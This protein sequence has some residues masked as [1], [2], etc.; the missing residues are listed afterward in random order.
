M[1]N[2]HDT[3]R[4]SRR[5]PFCAVALLV[6]AGTVSPAAAQSFSE[7]ATESVSR[8]TAQSVRAPA[9][10]FVSFDRAEAVMTRGYSRDAGGQI[11]V[12][13]VLAAVVVRRTTGWESLHDDVNRFVEELGREGVR[14]VDGHGDSRAAV[15]RTGSV[16]EAA[17]VAREARASGL[18]EASYVAQIDQSDRIGRDKRGRVLLPA[19]GD[20]GVAF[21][22]PEFANQWYLGNTADPEQSNDL[23]PILN[24][25]FTGAGVTVGV[26]SLDRTQFE[27]GYYS[28]VQ[29]QD[30]GVDPEGHPDLAGGINLT[31]SQPPN[32]QL[33]PGQVVTGMAGLI[34]ARTNNGTGI[35]GIAPGAELVGLISGTPELMQAAIDQD[36]NAIDIQVFEMGRSDP[37]MSYFGL[38]TDQFSDPDADF[39]IRAQQNALRNGRG[40][41]GIPQLFGTGA[42]NTEFPDWFRFI[43]GN[44]VSLPSIGFL[45]IDYDSGDF[46]P[47]DSVPTQSGFPLVSPGPRINYQQLV[48][49][50][51]AIVVSP[52]SQNE[53]FIYDTVMGTEVLTSV[54]AEID[55]D[56]PDGMVTLA[57]SP[58][59]G[60]DTADLV[61][62]NTAQAVLGGIIALMLEANPALSVRDIQHI[63]VEN[64]FPVDGMGYD[65]TLPYGVLTDWQVNGAIP[66]KPHSDRF[67]F[68]KL[69]AQ[70]AFEDALNWTPPSRLF[71]LDT[72][73]VPVEDAEIPSPVWEEVGELQAVMV[74]DVP[75]GVDNICVRQN[76]TIEQIAVTL[77]LAGEDHSDLL[78][79]LI[80]PQ[81]TVSVLHFPNELSE[82][83]T[84]GLPYF[85]HRFVTFKHWGEPAGGNW[86][87]RFR[88]FGPDEDTPVGDD[89]GDIVT[90]LGFRGLLGRDEDR[91]DKTIVDYRVEIFARDTGLEPFTGCPA[92]SGTCPGDINADGIVNVTD[93]AL[94]LQL[95]N[96]GDFLAD[97]NGDGLI[98]FSDISLFVG[99][100]QPGYCNGSGLPFNRPGPQPGSDRPNE[101]VVRPI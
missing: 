13:Q 97:V 95:Y 11:R 80:S 49:D 50:P 44:V 7:S 2:D 10:E 39:V 55:P 54:Y 28:D 59:A 94:F 86:R 5:V 63:L 45:D 91:S 67:G 35:V 48:S 34:G 101:P 89:E 26:V 75:V 31:L 87:M 99:L 40:R 64:S 66:S 68:G 77:N 92:G 51:R 32:T 27:S 61:D 56:E 72:G 98:N 20:R 17:I 43:F 3:R 37:D 53:T 73:T 52:I 93:L 74:L 12:H 70:G 6:A 9:D 46:L 62:S 33:A 16:G 85:D 84:A 69:D 23:L 21:N 8:P 18:F 1:L 76:F 79:E 58:G 60:G 57:Y 25:N 65:P 14:A 24:Q 42:G 100:W 41:K 71:I 82:N 36:N 30:F 81:G 29:G 88:D 78:I 15:I 83:S 4:Q 22:D 19:V 38:T 47:P 96:N 90:V